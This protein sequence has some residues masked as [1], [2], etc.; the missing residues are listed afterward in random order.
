MYHCELI[1]PKR[2]TFEKGIEL[3][4]L[5]SKTL[6][7]PSETPNDNNTRQAKCFS[8]GCYRGHSLSPNGVK[9]IGKAVDTPKK[10]ENL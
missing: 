2:K 8:L 10:W 3:L 5:I 7:K 4:S 1:R 6:Y 9:F